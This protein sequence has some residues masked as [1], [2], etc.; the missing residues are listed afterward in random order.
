MSDDFGFDA[1]H[2]DGSGHDS[3]NH[4]EQ[5]N[6]LNQHHD[7]FADNNDSL[8]QSEQFGHQAG[9]EDDQHF[10]NGHHVEYDNPGGTHFEQTD[11]TNADS[12]Q[13]GFE[14]DFGQSSVDAQHHDSAGELDELQKHFEAELDSSSHDWQG[15]DG[16]LS[17][18]NK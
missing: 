15:G 17:A 13:A 18:V 10:A 14:Q 1:G 8:H 2:D 9:F 6:D 3:F 12:H 4:A 5:E 11:F 7:A 16:E